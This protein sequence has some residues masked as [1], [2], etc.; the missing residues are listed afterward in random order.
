[1]AGRVPRLDIASRTK[2][3]KTI[4]SKKEQTM[5]KTTRVDAT[6]LP[7]QRWD[8]P[9]RG[10]ITWHT[11]ISADVTP[12]QS[13]TCGIASLQPGDHFSLHQHDEAELYFGISGGCDVTIDGVVHRLE[14]EIVLFIAGNAMHGILKVEQPVRFFYCFARDSFDQIAYRFLKDRA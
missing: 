8:D 13:L 10:S 3:P 5:N 1:M 9:D 12:T 7:A 4:P 14:P 6:A 2:R 11:M